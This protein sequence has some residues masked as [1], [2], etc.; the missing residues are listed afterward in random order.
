MGQ[1]IDIRE[2]DFATHVDRALAWINSG[3]IIAAPLENAYVFLVD[4]FFHDGVRAMHVLRGDELGVAAQVL[5][6]STAVLDGI[7]REITDD[8]RKLM[9]AFW[10]G[11]LS[12]Y[13]PPQLGLNWD[14]GD[15]KE[16]NEICVRVPSA[17][18]VLALLR[19]S[20]PLA[21]ASAALAGG[22]AIQNVDYI[23]SFETHLA[24]IFHEGELAA[25]AVSTIVRA[26]R[27]GISM[28]REGAIALAALQGEVPEIECEPIG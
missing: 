22:P 12:F 10:P 15:D 25:G 19:K 17:E 6:S 5:I 8:A 3:F 21:V 13:L 27:T 14:L 1:L 4:A 23:S 16:L 11:Q 2:G 9:R 20:G 24:G 28:L 26:N 18:F 7:A